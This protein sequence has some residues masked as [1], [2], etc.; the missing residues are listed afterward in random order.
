MVLQ[1]SPWPSH[2]GATGLLNIADHVD[3]FA[4][5]LVLDEV[6]ETDG[7]GV[8]L[9]RIE[10]LGGVFGGAAEG[11]SGSG[12]ESARFCFEDDGGFVKKDFRD[13]WLFVL[14]FDSEKDEVFDLVRFEVEAVDLL[15]ADLLLLDGG[16]NAFGEIASS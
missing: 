15:G 4:G 1:G 5:D 12:C 16:G 14:G 13:C 10:G 3:C 11:V 2:R 9:F 6:K 7:D 8:S